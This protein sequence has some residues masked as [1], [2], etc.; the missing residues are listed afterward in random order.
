VKLAQLDRVEREPAPCGVAEADEQL[1]E[2]ALPAAARARERDVL[3]GGD[4]QMEVLEHPGTVG[5][6]AE[7]DVLRP[8]AIEGLV[9]YAFNTG[10]VCTCPSRALIQESIYEEFMGCCLERIR[11]IGQGN[12]LDPPTQI[13]PQVS[14][15]QLEKIESYVRI[16]LEEGAELWIGGHPTQMEDE[17]QGGY[18]FE[19]T[20][21][22]GENSM[23]V[24]QEE[25][26]GP[27]LAVTTFKRRGRGR[28][29]SRMT[30]CTAS[31]PACGRATVAVPSA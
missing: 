7:S 1:G 12:P 2:R 25:I 26:F 17:L 20:V 24:F 21:L 11:A 13:G 29:R 31:G 4:P 6:V 8:K 19:P 23:R 16:G 28:W 30:R 9:L 15:A 10:E 3:A 22:K 27:A 14:S 5:F 18:Y